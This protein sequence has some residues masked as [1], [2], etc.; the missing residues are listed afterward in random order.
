MK[1]IILFLQIILVSLL[2]AIR[3]NHIRNKF[4]NKHKSK[5]RSSVDPKLFRKT[6]MEKL[7]KNHTWNTAPSERIEDSF[8]RNSNSQFGKNKDDFVSFLGYLGDAS[9]KVNKKLSE[10]ISK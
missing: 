6:Q 1:F 10:K 7:Q 9:Q 4:K 2:V 5:I 3:S 8:N